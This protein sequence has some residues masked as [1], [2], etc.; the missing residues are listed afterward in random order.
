MQPPPIPPDEQD[1]L[2]ALRSY[3]VLDTEPEVPYDQATDLAALICGV[4]FSLVTLVDGDRQWFKSRHGWD[5]TQSD[6]AISFCAH[7]ITEPDLMVVPDATA[8]PRFRGNPLVTGEPEIRFY[9]GAPL[10]NS[11]GH[12]LGTLC[13][14]DRVP[15]HLSPEQEQAMRGLRTLVMALLELRRSTRRL[16]IS[17]EILNSL[18]GVFYVFN[19]NGHFLRWNRR[20]EQI[21]GYS[22]KDFAELHPLDLF[23][24]AD[25]DHIDEKIQQVFAVGV[26]DVEATL[27]A[28]DGTVLPHYFTGR[29]LDLEGEPCLVG[30]G[31]DVSRRRELE[32]ERERLF[33]LSH[34][35]LCIVGFDGGFRDV[36]PAWE[37]VL[38][39][40]PE[41][42][43]GR[44]FAEFIHPDYVAR[45]EAELARNRGGH[46]TRNFENRYRHRDGGW[47]WMS[48]DSS[49]D[50]TRG[51]IYGTARDVTEE[52]A[53]AE[54]LRKSEAR[55]RTLVES[56]LDAI[57]TLAPDGTIASV[58]RAFTV[59]TGW[60]GNAWLGRSF[61]GLID[62]DALPL[63]REVFGK[64][65]RDE[66]MPVFE[67]PVV[68]R[69]G[70]RI[71][72]EIK[73]TAFEGT[74][75]ERWALLVARDIRARKALDERLHQLQRLDAVGRLA[76][77]VAH[78]FNNVLTVVRGEAEL[79]LGEPD[80]P[81]GV[82]ESLR[83]IQAAA[84]QGAALTGRLLALSRKQELRLG[85]VEL[86]QVIHHFSP[87][88]ERFVGN[89]CAVALTLC[90][91]STTVSADTGLLQQ[92]LMNLAINAG[93]AMP[94]GGTLHV[95]TAPVTVDEETAVRYPDAR[96]GRYVRLSVTDTGTGIAPEHLPHIFEPLFTT[97]DEGRGTGL[98]LAT[99]YSLVR[100]HGGW[101]D[102]QSTLGT[103]TTFHL[104]FPVAG[105]AG[106]PDPAAR[107]IQQ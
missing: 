57:I 61:E 14:F 28:R 25:R 26:A 89:S 30:M 56:A 36:N 48:W 75:G 10:I 92:V 4:P 83:H 55:Y 45:T 3:A 33:K 97:K 101:M 5:L 106:A 38:G 78:D 6:R 99:V 105:D 62:P 58:N 35:P 84:E 2:E 91:D 39:Y 53:V 96:A 9:A 21:T 41:F 74:P 23:R 18:P 104:F 95:S 79:L 1:R 59:I 60:D 94:D 13:V 20:F 50:L 69:D 31:V 85:D 70:R 40:P 7:A 29:L 63:A 19:R 66:G 80:L 68:A 16:D 42:L 86:N 81:G 17:D 103:G 11:E 8:D 98:G 22:A 71:P 65:G 77:G 47:R 88:L 64:L 32:D 73:A 90:P 51:T 76:A 52:K 43:I 27:I 87:M 49:V 46:E 82:A 34:D 37:R 12:A 93:D 44:R 67:L 100:Q 107:S 15:R 54:V 72:V 24:G 102:V